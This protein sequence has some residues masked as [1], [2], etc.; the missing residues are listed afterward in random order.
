M[1][2]IVVL[3]SGSGSNLAALIG[4]CG[5]GAI[6]GEIVGVVSNRQGAYGLTRAEAAGIPTV[7]VPFRPFKGQER[8]REAY[9]AHL[10]DH[11]EPFA[12]DLIVLAGFLRIVTATFLERFPGRVINLHPALPGELPG[13]HAI[14][15]AYEEAVAG[16]RT[17]TGVMV[18]EVV[19]E[20]DAG[21]VL[22]TAEVPIDPA[23]GLA[24][25]EE[26]IHATEH[27]LLVEVVAR[28]CAGET[29]S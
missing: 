23:A 3:V 19:V 28:L 10:A 20:V 22:G 15:R 1:K 9:D 21:P 26:D 17:H 14:E 12:P 7:H 27:R 24:K 8:A 2:R 29:V 13:L 11:I 16:T 5:R 6:S 25:L 4:A 18:H